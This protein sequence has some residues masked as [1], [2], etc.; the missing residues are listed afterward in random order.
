MLTRKPRSAQPPE[1]TA[2]R[3]ECAGLTVSKHCLF[4]GEISRFPGIDT[5]GMHSPNQRPLLRALALTGIISG[6]APSLAQGWSD[7]LVLTE[8][9]N[10]AVA[11]AVVG[12]AVAVNL[13]GNASTGLE[14]LLTNLTSDAP[15]FFRLR[16]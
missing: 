12:Q 11:K 5:G 9:N 3:L 14:G 13:P 7:T 6:L 2:K 8:T 15:L 1:I 16:Q 4:T 10:G